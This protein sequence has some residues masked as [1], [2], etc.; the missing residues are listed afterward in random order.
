[1][2]SAPV[3]LDEPQQAEIVDPGRL[4]VHDHLV[5]AAVRAFGELL[6]R[7]LE[8]R[9]VGETVGEGLPNLARLAVAGRLASLGDESQGEDGR[10][11]EILI[12]PFRAPGAGVYSLKFSSHAF[13]NV[14]SGRVCNEGRAMVYVVLSLT[15]VPLT[16]APRSSS[17]MTT[18]CGTNRFPTC[19]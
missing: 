10:P 8:E 2:P 7:A 5:V 14:A 15:N 4:P 3:P 6:A 13:V 9:E 18:V 12:P 17:R 1:M 11:P 16:V 19:W